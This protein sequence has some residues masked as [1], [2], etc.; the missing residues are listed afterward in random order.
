MSSNKVVR[1]TYC[2]EDVFCIPKNIN[3]EDKTQVESWGVKWNV[4]HI[5]LTNGKELKIL[6]RGWIDNYNFK[7]PDENSEILEADEVCC[8]LDEDNDEQFNEVNVEIEK[9]E[10]K[11]CNC[12]EFGDDGCK[13]DCHSKCNDEEDEEEEVKSVCACNCG[14]PCGSY[15]LCYHGFNSDCCECRKCLAELEEDE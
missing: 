7:Y 14:Q 4:L 6:S 2:V 13:C 10:E 11:C 12:W 15:D 3:L 5:Y 8:L 1:V 9:P